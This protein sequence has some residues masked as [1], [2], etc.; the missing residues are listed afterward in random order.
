MV[1]KKSDWRNTN[2][3]FGWAIFFMFLTFI[4]LV[5][6]SFRNNLVCYYLSVISGV[7]GLYWV[8][9]SWKSYVPPVKKKKKK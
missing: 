9:K 7:I 3:G 4:L 8:K 2:P 1:K 5:C 6:G